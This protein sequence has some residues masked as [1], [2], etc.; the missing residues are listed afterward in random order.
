MKVII[1]HREPELFLKLFGAQDSVSIAQLSCG[2]FLIDDRWVFE[3][4]TI[5]DLC[6]SLADGRLF[7]QALKLVQ[8]DHHPV[9]ILEG[10][11]SDIKECG[12]R[13]EAVQGA[14]INLSV[15]FGLPI[16]RSLE[17]E[18]TVRLMRYTV[19]QGV[20]FAQGGVQRAGYRPKGRKA[21][22][23]YVLQSLP[24]IGKTRAEKLLEHFGGI[25]AVISATENELAEIHG[26]GA[27]IAEKI[28][29]LVRESNGS[30][31]TK[32]D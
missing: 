15:F 16:L 31:R 17:P 5:S 22:Q 32:N 25:E 10:K 29:N 11:S 19:E 21:R 23:L 3:R 2:D 14:L 27:P 13:R 24:G 28:R 9:V 20:R 30:Y 26:I 6:V 18:E 12:T 1:D 7:K 8:S 4:K